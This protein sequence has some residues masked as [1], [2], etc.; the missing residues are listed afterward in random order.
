VKER[1]SLF[2]YKIF[3]PLSIL[4]LLILI[5]LLFLLGQ[6]WVKMNYAY[7]QEIYTAGICSPSPEQPDPDLDLLQKDFVLDLLGN[8]FA[9]I[10]ELLGEAEEQGY[11]SWHGPH[12]YMS[13]NLEKGPIRFC[14]PLDVG[15]KIAVSI[16][17][18][19]EHEILG[20]KVGMTFEEIQEIL[21]APAFGPELSMGDL[22]YMDYFFGET[23]TQMP[24]VF[25]S[26]SADAI[27]GPTQ[28]VFIK[29]EAFE[30]GYL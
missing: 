28:D 11:S 19:V 6:S 3:K 7:T 15:D 5:V 17:L 10:R 23:F 18:G 2:S 12:N 29:W 26:F 8:S 13:Y 21:G 27:N 24:E 1:I 20:V 16:L 25:I 14:S 4:I 9:E 22:Y 30:Y